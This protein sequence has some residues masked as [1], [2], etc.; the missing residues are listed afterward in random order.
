MKPVPEDLIQLLRTH[1][2]MTGREA[3]KRLGLHENTVYAWLRILGEQ[4]TRTGHARGARLSTS[5]DPLTFD[6]KE[7]LDAELRR[8]ETHLNT[9]IRYRDTLRAM[10]AALGD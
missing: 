7:R 6:S 10:R 8:V 4:V 2:P 3:A 5:V 1:G 9:V